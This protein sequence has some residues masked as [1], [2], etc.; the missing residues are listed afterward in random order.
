MKDKNFRSIF[1]CNSVNYS[2]KEIELTVKEFFQSFSAKVKAGYLLWILFH[3][4]LMMLGLAKRN[5]SFN[6]DFYPLNGFRLRTYDLS[7]FLIYTITPIVIYYVYTI[8]SDKGL[9]SKKI[10][11]LNGMN[12]SVKYDSKEEK[13]LDDNDDFNIDILKEET[14]F[15]Q[16]DDKIKKVENTEAY[17]INIEEARSSTG[18]LEAYFPSEPIIANDNALNDR[19][20]LRCFC[21]DTNSKI[22]FTA[23]KY[24]RFKNEEEFNIEL[25][26]GDTINLNLNKFVN[27]LL[28]Q[29]GKVLLLRDVTHNGNKSIFVVI[30]YEVKSQHIIKYSLF[31]DDLGGIF[32]WSVQGFKGINDTKAYEIFM[33]KKKYFRY[34]KK[35]IPC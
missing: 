13:V 28:I 26:F 18:H 27:D 25:N 21:G 5:Y 2:Y 3:F 1:K 24:I 15:Q 7:E 19:E 29:E 11:T 9:F 32:R 17:I 34:I 12:Y 22:I 6:G 8:F 10:I 35:F 4:I 16:A 33:E 30:E 23:Q 31:F 20:I 14:S